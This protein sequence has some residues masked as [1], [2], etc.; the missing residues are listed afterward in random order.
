MPKSYNSIKA[1][2]K[3]PN[4]TENGINRHSKSYKEIKASDYDF[5]VNNDYIKTF[6]NESQGLFKNINK[7]IEDINYNNASAKYKQKQN[8][9][10]DIRHKADTIRAYFNANKKNIDSDSYNSTIKYLNELDSSSENLLKGYRD[11]V[12]FMN[13]FEDEDNYNYW[14]KTAYKYKDSDL[15]T[16]EAIE[17]LKS[18]TKD[19]DVLDWLEGKNLDL[20]SERELGN[21]EQEALDRLDDAAAAKYHAANT[22]RK[23]EKIKNA[24]IT[25]DGKQVSGSDLLKMAN[26]RESELQQLTL[27]ANDKTAV[28]SPEYQ[29]LLVKK[30]EAAAKVE[31]M[32]QI[33]AENGLTYSQKKS[34]WEALKKYAD[35]GANNFNYG[36]SA[37][38]NL[39][40]GNPLSS[41]GW[42][43]N[44]FTVTRNFYKGKFD[45]DSI[46]AQEYAKQADLPEIVGEL[47][48]GTV[49]ALPDAVMGIMTGGFSKAATAA[50]LAATAAKNTS[51][52]LGK[53]GLTV[54]AMAKNPFYW[55]SFVREVGSDYEEA[56]ENGAN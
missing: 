23:A 39:I 1:G 17:K 43:D 16:H 45:Y 18:E 41:L 46:L 22:Y 4:A 28:N 40:L 6:A 21:L 31:E 10:K 5:G 9:L 32:K 35:K 7:D 12:D 33:F 42:T 47:V 48:S 20:Y 29:R 15:S 51:S 49:A 50:G 56:V 19:S 44:P 8:E 30:E 34:V 55:T 13:Q 26:E 14:K 2:W 36:W 38:L 24:N 52:I 11:S 25:I 53:A 3:N 27:A 37:T 54:Q